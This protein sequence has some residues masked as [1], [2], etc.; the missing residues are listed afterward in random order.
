[1]R[2]GSRTI[3]M[4]TGSPAKHIL[5]FAV[6]LILT[7]VGQQFYMIADASIVGRGVGVRA[8]AAVGAT[9]WCYWLILWTV[10][11][12]TQGFSTFV[13]RAFGK[14]NYQEMSRVIALSAVLCA[15]IGSI[16]TLLGVVCAESLLRLLNTPDDILSGA[17]GY[18]TTMVA[19][20]LIVMGYNMT[21]AILRS[22]GDGKTPLTA[23]L[24]AALLNIALDC[25]FVFV[26]RWGI[27]GAAA[28]SLIAQLTSFVYCAVAISKIKY[29][30]LDRQA[31]VLDGNRIKNMLLFGLP[32]A[33]QY[34][35][36]TGGGMILQSSVNLQG[37][38]FIA[39]YTAT[40][41]L[42]SFL[43]CFA[44]S[45]GVSACTFLSQNFG[46]KLYD[47]VKQGVVDSVKIVSL[48]ALIITGIALLTRWQILRVFIDVNEAGG[49]EALEIA[50][51]YLTIMA[52]CFIIVH[53]LHVFRNVL[54]AIG[55]AVWALASGVAEFIARVLMSQIV[56]H[57]I[58]T[59][60][61]FVAEPASW[62]GAMLCV[63]LPYFYY[64]KRYLGFLSKEKVQ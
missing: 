27:I 51:R 60:A 57:W 34:V 19:G 16:L 15:V 5:S 28:A 22:L 1:M 40:N 37:S 61:L 52:P 58:G 32:I 13:A 11:G 14:K 17:T 36:I 8:F 45:F 3:N 24:I 26:L 56:I 35:V 55:V 7:N 29:I 48:T 2:M 39:G 50:V 9:D 6:P 41:K 10:G 64:Q 18:L 4:T 30:H 38:L 44:M 59:D 43:Q 47:R 62:L 31:W 12:L 20:T 33:L 25:L 23:M 63:S 49:G 21:A 46:A 53:L 42:Y 54:Q